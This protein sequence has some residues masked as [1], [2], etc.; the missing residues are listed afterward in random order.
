MVLRLVTLEYDTALSDWEM[1]LA[2][3]GNAVRWLALCIWQVEAT[4]KIASVCAACMHPDLQYINISM[5]FTTIVPRNPSHLLIAVTDFLTDGSTVYTT[6][7]SEIAFSLNKHK[8]KLHSIT[9]KMVVPDS[10]RC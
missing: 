10:L 1:G 8:G 3:A 4:P 9:H 2:Y 5:R 7:L 6:R